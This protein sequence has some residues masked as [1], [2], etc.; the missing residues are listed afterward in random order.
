MIEL[1]LSAVIGA[2][3]FIFLL[4]IFLVLRWRG[5]I[6]DEEKARLEILYEHKRLFK[7]IDIA[8]DKARCDVGLDI[9]GR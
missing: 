6:A 4:N 5:Q 7:A 2:F 9:M 8:V 1:L 3:V